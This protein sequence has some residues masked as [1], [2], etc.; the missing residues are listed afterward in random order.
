MAF[1]SL[2]TFIDSGIMQAGVGIPAGENPYWGQR[3]RILVLAQRALH[4]L[5]TQVSEDVKR[6]HLLMKSFSIVLTSGVGPLDAAMLSA[7]IGYG[8]VRDADGNILSKVDNYNDLVRS[9]VPF[10]GYYAMVNDTV[11]TRQISS[12]SLTDTSTPLTV[13]CSYV[14]LATE[15]PDEITDDAT[16][17]LAQMI[18]QPVSG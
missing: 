1:A 13:Y 5:A 7:M 15:V 6:R 4:S 9:Q 12:G 8:S 14:P 18:K 10:F 16:N 11:F 17:L 3:A 2:D